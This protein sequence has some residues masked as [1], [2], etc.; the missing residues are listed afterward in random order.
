[1]KAR[2][3]IVEDEPPIAQEIAFNLEDHGFEIIGIAHSSDKALDLLYKDLPD[4]ALLDI[5]IN[6]SRNGIELAHIINEKYKIPFVFLTSYADRDTIEQAAI[7]FPEGY[8]VKP[9]KDNDLAP[10]LEVAL[11]KRKVK[12]KSGLPSLDLINKKAP[13][14][15]TK[16]EFKVIAL[17]WDG[18]TN[19]EIATELFISINTVKSHMNNI[20]S[21]LALKNKPQLI[22]YLRDF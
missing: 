6:G 16:S 22:K 1:M 9:F 21:K 2:V 10:A 19:G 12:S 11:L 8:I 13:V 3:L 5:S 18:K 14:E 4:I 15:I 17:I 7:T 20:Y